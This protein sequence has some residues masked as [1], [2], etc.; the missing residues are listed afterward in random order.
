MLEL[1][2]L[3][4]VVVLK[5]VRVEDFEDEVEVGFVGVLLL[6][7]PVDLTELVVEGLAE[8]VLVDFTEPVDPVALEDALEL[9]DFTELVDVDLTELLEVEV[10]FM[11]LLELD[12][13]TEV[14]EVDVGFGKV[15]ETL[16]DFE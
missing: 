7:V 12:D 2:L 13:L 1:V 8:M 3:V 4:E 9:L 14:V 11:E 6:L 10:G 5:V 15:L 16:D